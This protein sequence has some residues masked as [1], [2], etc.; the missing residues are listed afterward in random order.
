MS[1]RVNFSKDLKMMSF[2]ALCSSML[3]HSMTRSLIFNCKS[4]RRIVIVSKWFWMSFVSRNRNGF[5]D[6]DRRICG[7]LLS[8]RCI[9][10][11]RFRVIRF[12]TNDMSLS[13]LWSGLFWC[14]RLCRGLEECRRKLEIC[15]SK[16][17]FWF[18]LSQT[19][20]T[21]NEKQRSNLTCK[22]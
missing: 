1:F 13:H 15:S 8:L 20:T 2:L 22:A 6:L 19:K 10:K 3:T 9:R 14:C 21:F 7:R 18:W 11:T 17:I 5:S 12:S 16:W 4:W